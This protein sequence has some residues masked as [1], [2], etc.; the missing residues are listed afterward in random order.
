MK[1]FELGEEFQKWNPYE[2]PEKVDGGYLDMPGI[3]LQPL[4]GDPTNPNDA[5]ELRH[6]YIESVALPNVLYWWAFAFETHGVTWGSMDIYELLN[7][8][9]QHWWPN[10]LHVFGRTTRAPFVKQLLEKFPVAE[11]RQIR[12][13][14]YKKIIGLLQK[15]QQY[16]EFDYTP[17]PPGTVES[18]LGEDG[19]VNEQLRASLQ[20][21]GK[22]LMEV[23][24]HRGRIC[25]QV[26]NS[27]PFMDIACKKNSIKRLF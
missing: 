7:A 24:D 22:K 11:T 20:D 19:K 16:W 25:Q 17:A 5:K 21:E 23:W 26:L 14:F 8:M 6:F 10:I 27:D 2:E 4:I 9:H 13:K 12:H 1:G 18:Y 15:Q 3:I